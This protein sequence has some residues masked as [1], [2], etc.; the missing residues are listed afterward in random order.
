[1]KIKYIY[2]LNKLRLAIKLAKAASL[3][4]ILLIFSKQL[5]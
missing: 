1:M 2:Q 3:V 5:K 4:R